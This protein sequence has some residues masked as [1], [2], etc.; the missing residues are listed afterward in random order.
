MLSFVVDVLVFFFVCVLSLFYR[1]SS[2][3]LRVCAFFFIRSFFFL[4]LLAHEMLFFFFGAF[5]LQCTVAL[6]CE[7]VRWQLFDLLFFCF[8]FVP[9]LYVAR[10]K[11]YSDSEGN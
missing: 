4:L 8:F 3:R 2:K 7:R 9:I 11:G 1:K 5:A 6:H 10:I